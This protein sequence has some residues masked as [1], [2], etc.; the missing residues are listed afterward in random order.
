MTAKYQ[1]WKDIVFEQIK[2]FN[3]DV[4][5]FGS[6]FQVVKDDLGINKSDLV[7][8]G[9]GWVDIYRKAGRIFADAYHPGIPGNTE[10]Y[11]NTIAKHV[12]QTLNS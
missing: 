9:N 11:V 10:M 5:V 4:I 6:T 7:L 2:L 8:T 1:I 3:P 12:R